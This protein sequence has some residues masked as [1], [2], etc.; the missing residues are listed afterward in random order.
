MKAAL[1]TSALVLALGISSP[2]VRADHHDEG[3]ETL[4]QV[5]AKHIAA[6]GGRDAWNALDSL[7]ATGEYT[8]F[9][10]VE[11]F[12]QRKTRDRKYYMNHA[13][14]DQP[15]VMGFD[16]QTA[17]WDNA[18]FGKGPRAI[19]GP[20]REVLERDL[21]FATPLFDLE[22]AGHAATLL[23]AQE[24]DGIDVIAIELQRADESKEIWYLDPSTYLE[25]GRD[26]P[27]SDFGRPM[28]QRTFFDDFREVA[29]VMIPFYTETEWYTRHRVM[30]I[31]SIE[32]NVEAD[33]SLFS[34]PP[35]VGMEK[36]QSLAG[37][38]NVAMET[39]ESPA[40]PFTESQGQSTIEGRFRGALF[41]E[42][43][44]TPDGNDAIRTLSYDQFRD[45]YVVTLI[46]SSNNSMD[47]L[48]GGW[49]EDG[50]LELDD[51][52][53]ETPT[54]LF[55]MT[56]H[57][58]MRLYEIGPD[59]FKLERENSIDGGETWAVKEKSTYSRQQATD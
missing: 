52:V 12:T 35:P 56:I 14:G 21:D 50:A 18:F 44:T 58:R 29:G 8:A 34:M 31:A 36:L 22:S 5:V 17:W 30:A 39:R 53:T 49:N 28:T 25:V 3:A 55:G 4:D 1:L 46:D 11:P 10:K 57:E 42:T 45:R 33:D 16:G 38:W 51:V 2:A 24:L 20:D 59:S 6:K 7:E 47:I 32:V 41:E 19:E 15:V 23:G 27:G 26:S 43:W 48:A 13:W 40:A 9:S 54:L 37:S